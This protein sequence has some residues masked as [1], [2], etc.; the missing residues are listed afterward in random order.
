MKDIA[1]RPVV[2]GAAVNVARSLSICSVLR[3]A[4]SSEPARAAS[5]RSAMRE[6]DDPC[7]ALTV[8]RAFQPEV[9]KGLGSRFGTATTMWR[10]RFDEGSYPNGIAACV[11]G[12]GAT[13]SPASRVTVCDFGSVRR[14]C[15]C[16]SHDGTEERTT[17]LACISDAPSVVRPT[18]LLNANHNFRN[19]THR[20]IEVSNTPISVNS[21]RRPT[22]T[23]G[24]RSFGPWREARCPRAQRARRRLDFTPLFAATAP[25]PYQ[26]MG[27]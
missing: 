17:V 9:Q 27:P 22:S 3:D 4:G 2:G 1:L 19:L 8:R 20:A 15:L 6:V 5:C 24:C 16:G 26:C 18:K 21:D 23:G 12:F 11:A 7:R 10:G 14:A 25:H 13:T